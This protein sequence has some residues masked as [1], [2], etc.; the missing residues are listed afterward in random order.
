MIGIAMDSKKVAVRGQGPPHDPEIPF[1]HSP[2]LHQE[3]LGIV[4]AT[5]LHNDLGYP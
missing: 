3:A 1:Q 5:P 4:M 2:T